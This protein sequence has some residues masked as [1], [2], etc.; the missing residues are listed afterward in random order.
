MPDWEAT[1]MVAQLYNEAPPHLGDFRFSSNS[2]N[3][4]PGGK[5]FWI[6]IDHPTNPADPTDDRT[7]AD[8][9][10]D[11][12]DPNVFDNVENAAPENSGA[13]LTQVQACAGNVIT[14]GDPYYFSKGIP[15]GLGF[16]S[17]P[18]DL[19]TI[20]GLGTP[21]P[22][23]RIQDIDYDERKLTLNASPCGPVWGPEHQVSLAY[24]VGQT[25]PHIGINTYQDTDA[26][27]QIDILDNCIGLSND[28]MDWDKDG[29]GDACD[30]DEGAS[31]DGPSG[32][33]C[34]GQPVCE[35]P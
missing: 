35:A 34:A 14:V 13:T 19:I 8:F 25:K 3:G 7:L 4:T 26:D 9:Q 1:V 20:E 17:H 30:T 16:A 31:Q 28:Q 29:F 11:G 15:E 32:L 5:V 27:S 24:D 12:L 2:L 33:W 21:L 6:E 22:L 23:W 10:G 18:G